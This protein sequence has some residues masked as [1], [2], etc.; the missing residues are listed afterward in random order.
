M[1]ARQMGGRAEVR[2]EG[3]QDRQISKKYSV[4]TFQNKASAEHT[5]VECGQSMIPRDQLRN[6]GCHPVIRGPECCA[7]KFSL[8]RAWQHSDKITGVFWQIHSAAR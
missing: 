5:V 7:V 3:I 6:R 2:G 1:F 4:R 8:C